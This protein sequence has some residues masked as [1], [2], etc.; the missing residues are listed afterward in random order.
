[1]VKIADIYNPRGHSLPV[2]DIIRYISAKDEY[3]AV[4]KIVKDHENV[5]SL[6]QVSYKMIDG[7]IL[8][9]T[10][11]CHYCVPSPF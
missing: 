2:F 10:A 4:E 11:R 8:L 6:L 7:S 3:E 1:M 5:S 9:R